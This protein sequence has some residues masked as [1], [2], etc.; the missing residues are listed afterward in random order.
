MRQSSKP[1]PAALGFGFVAGLIAVPIFHQ[2]VFALLHAAG[3]IP[4]PPYNMTRTPPF[5][6]PEVVSASFWGGVW[7]VIFV[8]TVARLFAGRRYW[9]AAFAFGAVA[10]TAVYAL[11]VAPLKTGALPAPL[12]PVLLIGG[13]L[14]GAWGLGTAALLYLFHRLRGPAARP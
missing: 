3:V 11:V 2:G 5:G 7:G 9:V 8:L 6:V 4:V 12:Y 14:N 13:L 1:A 10:L